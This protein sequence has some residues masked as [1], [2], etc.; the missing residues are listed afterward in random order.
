MPR[1]IYLVK[2]DRPEGVSVDEMNAYIEEAVDTWKGQ[3]C[4]EEPLF[5]MKGNVLSERAS[6]GRIKALL[7]KVKRVKKKVRKARHG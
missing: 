1:E 4:P 6:L 7:K 5:D 2:V 3:M